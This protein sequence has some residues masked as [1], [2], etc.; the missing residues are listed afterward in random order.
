MLTPDEGATLLRLLAL[1]HRCSTPLTLEHRSM[2]GR[3]VVK[4]LTQC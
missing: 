3:Y 4:M 1:I 2:D